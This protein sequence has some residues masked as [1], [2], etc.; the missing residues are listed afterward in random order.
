MTMQE[1]WLPVHDYEGLYEVSNLG[2]I[3][4]LK[5]QHVPKT[6]IVKT[7]LNRD[8]YELVTLHN[9]SRKTVS[10]HRLVALHFIENPNNR[11]E[12]NHIDENKTNNSVSNLEWLSCKENINYGT[13]ITRRSKPVTNGIK[14][15][16]S[17]T[18]AALELGIH[19]NM[20]YRVLYGK[21]NKTAGF[22]WEWI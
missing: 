5:R 1:I 7:R 20:I 3:R 16:D 14:V 4:S 8:G 13:G 22:H 11:E 17:A 18:E 21:R 15:W 2:R 12:V 6:H 10:V 9:K 19:R